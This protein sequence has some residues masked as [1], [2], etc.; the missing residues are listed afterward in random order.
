MRVANDD[1]LGVELLRGTKVVG[2]W[3]DKVTGFQVFNGELD[4]EGCIGCNS[5][6]VFR[7]DELAGGLV[8]LGWNIT[9][10]DGVA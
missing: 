8:G 6:Q 4:C 3:V 7:E 5:V 1:V 2:L 10:W 9:H